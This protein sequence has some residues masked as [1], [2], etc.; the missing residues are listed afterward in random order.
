MGGWMEVKA[1][2][3]IAYSNKK[4]AN[5]PNMCS[6]Q[7]LPLL[8]PCDTP[9]LNLFDKSYHNFINYKTKYNLSEQS[10][11]L[12]L[13]SLVLI[14]TLRRTKIWLDTPLLNGAKSFGTPHHLVQITT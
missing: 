7:Q 9:S 4:L 8:T 3:R 6:G 10:L 2:L 1:V 11:K 5:F 13:T 14:T 12:I